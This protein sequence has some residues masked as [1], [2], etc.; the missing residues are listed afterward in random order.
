M[1]LNSLDSSFDKGKIKSVDQNEL[2]K[3][4]FLLCSSTVL[5]FI[6]KNKLWCKSSLLSV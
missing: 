2:K 6:L 3:D 5:G 1:I 4:D